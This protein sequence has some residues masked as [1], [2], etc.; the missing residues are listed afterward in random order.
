MALPEYR[1]RGSAN[2]GTGSANPTSPTGAEVG[3]YVVE[4]VE[5]AGAVASGEAGAAPTPEEAGWTELGTEKNGNTRLTAWGRILSSTTYNRKMICTG[6]NHGLGQIIAIK[7]GTFEP[8]NPIHKIAI[9]PQAKTKAV[10]YPTLETKIAECLIINL[11]TADLPDAN[12]EAEF[13]APTNASLG[14]PTERADNS[15]AEGD[16]GAIHCVTGTKAVAGSVSATTCTAVTEAARVLATLAITPLGGVEPTK[17]PPF[18]PRT[19]R[20]FLL[21]R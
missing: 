13:G 16:G 19:Q 2:A 21:R 17:G 8:T 1:A 6:L 7:K 9:A 20:N 4:W 14:S 5:S 11:G 18:A 10:S 12:G 3:D 15:T